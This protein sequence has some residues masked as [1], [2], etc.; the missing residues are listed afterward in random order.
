MILKPLR[1]F[2]RME[3]IYGH[4]PLKRSYILVLSH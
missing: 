1:T 2:E 3:L 4:N